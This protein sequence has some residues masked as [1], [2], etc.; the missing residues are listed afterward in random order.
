MT[1]LDREL[2]LEIGCEE[3]PAGWLP[4]LTTQLGVRLEARLVE[5]RLSIDAPVQT[6]STP[7]RLAVA[8]GRVADRQTD[9]EALVTGPPVSAAFDA[10]GRPTPAAVGFARKQ[11]VEVAELERHATAKGE[12]LAYLRRQRGRAAVEVLP[13]VVGALL[14]DLTFPKQMR[15]DAWLDDGRGDLL[16]G[17]PI[18]WLLFLFG[19]RVVPFTIRRTALAQSA[20]VHDVRSAAMTYGHRVLASS[21]RA[22]RAIRVRSFDD[23]RSRLAEHFVVLER[24]ERHERLAGELDA[25]AGRLHGRVGGGATSATLLDEVAD[26]VE[27]PSVVSGSFPAEF[28][29]LP[30]EVLATTMVHHQ[31]FFPITD[32]Q[33]KLLPHFL[34]VTNIEVDNPR[35]IATNAERV[36]VARLRDAKFFWEADRR[37][38]LAAAMDRLDTVLF[39]Q[40]LGSYRAKAERLAALAGWVAAEAFGAPAVEAHAREAG[41]LAKAD[42][43]TDMVREFTELQGTVGGIYAREDGAPDAVWKA[44]YYHY[45]PIGVEAAAPPSRD[46]LGEAAVSWAAVS[47]ADKMDSVVGLF[48]AGERPTGTRD[49]FGIR[50]QLQGALKILVDLPE[51]MPRAPAVSVATIVAKAAEAFDVPVATFAADLYGFVEDRLRHLFGTR[52]SRPD[53]IA[54]ALFGLGEMPAPLVVRRRLEALRQVRASAEFAALAV[55]FKRVRNL[56]RE[57]SPEP[58]AAY[59]TPFDRT[60]LTEPVETELLAAFDRVAPSIRSAIAGGD[61]P[62]ALHEAST[63]RPAVDRFFAEVFVMA[64]DAPVRAARLRLLVELRDLV[65]QIADISQL[66]P[67]A[68]STSSPLA[69]PSRP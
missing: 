55:L 21:G 50:R 7:R 31:H 44:I 18:R 16:F 39:H 53:E 30:D 13:E 40:K 32:T 38:P 27:Y 67:G 34:A 37:Q 2:L 15:W 49:P 17:R 45:L 69:G 36:L 62:R 47:L 65:L 29:S 48:A 11:G 63:L 22:G 8:I 5:A 23:Y 57:V 26:L 61:H 42:L 66:A 24:R 19:G 51:L 46:D 43:T 28:L 14:R 25:Q 12:Y 59:P 33:G 35:R 20:S 4:D 54:A 1:P 52:G 56:A 41:R 10:S 6:F 9:L 60:R 68:D 64:D 3:L 58:L